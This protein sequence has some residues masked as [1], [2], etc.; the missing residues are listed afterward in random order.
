MNQQIITRLSMNI[1]FNRVVINL[2]KL[3]NK[4][5]KTNLNFKAYNEIL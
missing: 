4:Q 3:K 1:F 2:I 5:T